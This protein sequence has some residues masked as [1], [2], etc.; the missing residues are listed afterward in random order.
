M[1][2]GGGQPDYLSHFYTGQFSLT[3][4]FFNPVML[5]FAA[6]LISSYYFIGDT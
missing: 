5:V 4:I 6:N 3:G 2:R 1:V